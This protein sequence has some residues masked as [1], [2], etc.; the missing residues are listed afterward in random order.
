M[1][2]IVFKITLY[3]FALYGFICFI[4]F[5]FKHLQRDIKLGSSKIAF[6]LL[7]KDGEEVIEG[8][9]RSIFQGGILE[10]LAKRN[11]CYIVDMDSSDQTLKILKN[12]QETYNV[13]VLSIDE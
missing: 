13:E 12:L 5:I 8:I 6:V 11:N 7:V 10:K 1:I 9:I 2:L 3:I 4:Y